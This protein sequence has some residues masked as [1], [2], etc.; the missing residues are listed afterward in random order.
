MSMKF[1]ENMNNS[2]SICK[3]NVELYCVVEQYTY[4][5]EKKNTTVIKLLFLLPLQWKFLLILWIPRFLLNFIKLYILEERH[6]FFFFYSKWN[7]TSQGHSVAGHWIPFKSSISPWE[8]FEKKKPISS[9]PFENV[10]VD[11][12]LIDFYSKYFSFFFF[13]CNDRK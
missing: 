12:K 13:F 7:F 3:V 2:T 4:K 11:W 5:K 6:F 9:F 8:L 1:R 10:L